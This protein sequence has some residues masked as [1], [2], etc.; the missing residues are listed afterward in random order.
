[1]KLVTSKIDVEEEINVSDV[2]MIATQNNTSL[3][4]CNIPVFL[5]EH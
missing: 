4:F 3:S 2:L 1:M 5:K